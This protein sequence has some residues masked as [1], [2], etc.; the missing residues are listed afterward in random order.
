M[1]VGL[2]TTL[3]F[4]VCVTGVHAQQTE[5]DS[6][7]AL[8]GTFSALGAASTQF[9]QAPRDGSDVD[10]GFRA[11]LYPTWKLSYHWTI[12]GAYQVA[13]RPYYY[14]TFTSQGHGVRGSIIQGYLGY[15][16]VWKDASIVARVG[17][18][19]SAFGAFPLRYDDRDNPLINIP[20]QYGYYGSA[21]T[22]EALP[23]AQ[24]DAT[25]KRLDG[26]VQLTNSSPANPRSFTKSEQYGAWTAGVGLTVHQ[27][28]RIG[29]SA[30]RGPYLDH[31]SQFYRPGEADPHALPGTGAGLE[32]QWGYGHWNI[33]GEYQTFVMTYL[34]TRTFH[35][36]AAYAEAERDL[37]ARWYLAA[38]YGYLT[39]TYLYES[40]TLET[41]V[42]YRPSAGQI[43]K[44]SYEF[45]HNSGANLPNRTLAVQ[46]VMAIRPLSF[47]KD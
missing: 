45:G 42:G 10:A 1:R 30:Y 5:A 3:L 35:E 4:L 20:A 14:S 8:S 16:Q 31:Q 13:S 22:L 39:S 29:A 27:G 7:F 33:H 38:R 24:I 34:K 47:A 41:A 12:A 43:V 6:G 19:S 44:V 9:G 46:Y 2:A 32:T 15:T 11:M 26:R 37:N 23:G 28:F 36:R 17:E 18:L 40:Q 21:A 25:W